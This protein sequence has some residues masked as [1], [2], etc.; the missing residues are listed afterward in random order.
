[1]LRTFSVSAA[2]LLDSFSNFAMASL[3]LVALAMKDRQ[4]AAV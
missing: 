2:T 4:C 3:M 1:M